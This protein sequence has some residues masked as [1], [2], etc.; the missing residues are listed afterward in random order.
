MKKR[1]RNAPPLAIALLALA[2]GV[3]A[4]F[5][6]K[7][8]TSVAA[9]AFNSWLQSFAHDVSEAGKKKGDQPIGH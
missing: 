3:V 1:K 2:I 7:T 9:P 4:L 8:I 6:I 5:N